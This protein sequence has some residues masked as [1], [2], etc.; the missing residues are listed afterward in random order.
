MAHA[1]KLALT[2]SEIVELEAIIR[3]RTK[4]A[5]IVDRSKMLLY[6]AY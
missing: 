6:N 3:Q 1:K 2:E 4:Q 5:Q